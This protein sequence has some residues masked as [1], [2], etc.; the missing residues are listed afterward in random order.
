MS[1]DTN[2]LE[3]HEVQDAQ[4]IGPGFAD[5]SLFGLLRRRRGWDEGAL[6]LIDEPSHDQLKGIDEIVA[7]LH[8]IRTT[9]TKIIVLPDFD[10]DGI[11][12]GTL[13]YAGLSELGFD[14]ELYVPDFRRG[15]DVSPEAVQELIARHPGVGAIITCDGGVNSHEGVQAAKDAG[16]IVLVTDHH[17]QLDLGSPADVI[18]NPMRIDETYA[19]PSICGAFVLY[20][21]LMAYAQRHAPHR[22]GDI[23]Y[24]KLFAGIGTVS[25]VMDLKYENRQL[26]RDS[27]SIARMLYV[28]IPAADLATEYDPEKS[29]LLT[30]LR[31]QGGH[32]PAYLDA[33]E[34]FAI[35]LQA[36]REHGGLRS[37]ADLDEGFYGFYL[38]PT[39]NAIRRIGGDMTD[40]FGAFTAPTADE[41]LACMERLLEGNELRKE[42]TKE[43]LAELEERDQPFA[44]FAYFTDAPTGMLGLIANQMMQQTGMPVVVV[45]RPDPVTGAVGGSG[46]S[47][48]WYP[49]ISTLAPAGFRAVGHENAC[50]VGAPSLAEFGE[51][52]ELLR[53]S[54]LELHAAL[55]ASGEL[56]RMARAD[57]VLGS[58]E[59]CDASLDDVEQLL[60]LA[61]GIRT[62]TPFGH[63]FPRPS[64]ELVIDLSKCAL[65]PLGDEGKHLRIVTRSG[66]KMLWWNQGDQL[67]RLQGLAQSS[68]PGVSIA[69]ATGGVSVNEF[70]GTE[71]AQVVIDALAVQDDE[72]GDDEGA[73]WLADEEGWGA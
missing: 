18:V 61:R 40:A 6:A 5:E 22:V 19:H 42:L 72:E 32:H 14:V 60:D 11:T 46:R 69:R 59:E 1:T 16:L 55:E 65:S 54:S 49:I 36:F 33:F 8:R 48:G 3:A 37:R 4:G 31:A 13:G 25:D 29:L 10:M 15:H 63:G 50:G 67:G 24:L 71:S 30:L 28:S 2:H 38:A 34:G 57:L 44:P 26:V 20:Q 47:P 35:A 51:L 21:V 66:L 12:S 56:Q 9:G 45:R 53:S 64:I 41:K 70:M 39:F 52:V 62:M 7:H 23:S 43:H 58:T 27:L 73:D 17:K 68:V